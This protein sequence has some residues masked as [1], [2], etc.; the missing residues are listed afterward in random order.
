MSLRFLAIVT[1]GTVAAAA[2]PVPL[3]EYRE[4]LKTARFEVI[5]DAI[6]R[7]GRVDYDLPAERFEVRSA[8]ARRATLRVRTSPGGEWRQ[9]EIDCKP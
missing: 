9:S 6:D 2:A 5:L 4:S 8:T 7:V 1:I 3:R